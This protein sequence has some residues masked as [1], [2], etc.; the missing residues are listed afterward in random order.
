MSKDNEKYRSDERGAEAGEAEPLVDL[1][2][3]L[4]AAGSWDGAPQAEL[5]DDTGGDS[6]IS[7]IRDIVERDDPRD[8]QLSAEH[9]VTVA[10]G[11]IAGLQV[12]IL[13]RTEEM[14]DDIREAAD[15]QNLPP[16]IGKVRAVDDAPEG[17]RVSMPADTFF[18]MQK[19]LAE[20]DPGGEF[21]FTS[22][23]APAEEDA[24]TRATRESARD[25]EAYGGPF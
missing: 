10:L 11:A 15:W 3:R 5:A 25:S 16:L 23:D 7:Q 8:R 14:L 2:R 13:Q 4:I 6:L 1:C 21:D 18:A 20:L 17:G 19:R 9:A 22:V 12:D 24:A